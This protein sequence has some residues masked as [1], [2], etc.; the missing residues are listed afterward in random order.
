MN[1][2]KRNIGQLNDFIGDW[3]MHDVTWDYQDP[4]PEST[5]GRQPGKLFRSNY[6]FAAYTSQTWRGLRLTK[7]EPLDTDY[8]NNRRFVSPFDWAPQRRRPGPLAMRT[9]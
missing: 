4:P 6:G 3:A 9:A 2:Q 8:A 5:A 7:V 1:G